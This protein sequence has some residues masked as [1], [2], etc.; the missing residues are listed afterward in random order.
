MSGSWPR[1]LAFLAKHSFSTE[2]DSPAAVA[3]GGAAAAATVSAATAKEVAATLAAMLGDQV[4]AQ[5][6]AAALR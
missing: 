3:G 5:A 1:V 4:P 2:G 6:Q